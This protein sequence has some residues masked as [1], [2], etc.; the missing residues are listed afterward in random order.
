V[1]PEAG[2]ATVKTPL[3]ANCRADRR[4]DQNPR[5]NDHR[6]VEHHA[7]CLT[8]TAPLN[9]T[10]AVNWNADA[11][12][13][14]G[15]LMSSTIANNGGSAAV[16]PEVAALPDRQ[17]GFRPEGG[18]RSVEGSRRRQIQKRDATDGERRQNH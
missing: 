5:Q 2:R 15:V 8:A 17:L 14:V 13:V 18:P 3:E 12:P 16:S 1:G 11:M 9:G 4:R 10:S 6:F 7:S